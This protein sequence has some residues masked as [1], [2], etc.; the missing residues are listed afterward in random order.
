MDR[1]PACS[2]GREQAV[3]RCLVAQ[4]RRR[5][6]RRQCFG[7]ATDVG[8]RVQRRRRGTAGWRAVAVRRDARPEATA[9]IPRRSARRGTDGPWLEAVGIGP[10]RT[11]RRRGG[12]RAARGAAMPAERP[13]RRQRSRARLCCFSAGQRDFDCVFSKKLNRS[14]QSGE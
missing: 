13:A 4:T 7:T 8:L 14:A 1:L 11:P 2:G 12:R 3:V 6:T 5:Y 10:T 9:R